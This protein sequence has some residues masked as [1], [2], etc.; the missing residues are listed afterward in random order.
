MIII[1]LR[2]FMLNVVGLNVALLSVVALNRCSFK[3]V[4]SKN[5]VFLR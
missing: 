2:G 5:V 1:I 3:N 4:C